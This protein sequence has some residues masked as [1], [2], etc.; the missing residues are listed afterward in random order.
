MK[1]IKTQKEWILWLGF[2]LSMTMLVGTLMMFGLIDQ[3]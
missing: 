2:I 3:K 1:T